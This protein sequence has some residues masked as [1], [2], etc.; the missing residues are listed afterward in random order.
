MLPDARRI[1]EAVALL[2]AGELVAFPT[3]TV[4][5]LGAD[6]QN[7]FAV[8]RIFAV[9]GRPASHPLIVHFSNFAAARAWAAEVPPTAERLA[10]AF[11]PGPLTLVLPKAA[12][13]PAAVTG[14]QDSVALRAPAHPVARALLAAFGRGIAAPSANRYGRISPTRAADVREELG[15]RI[16][17]VLDG[18]DCE[19]GLESTIVACLG[20]RV[21]LLRPGSISRSQ[22]E[23]VVGRVADPDAAAPRAPG[24]DRSHY[25]PGTPL[26]LVDGGSLARAVDTALA[27]GERVAVLA[28]TAGFVESDRVTWHRMPEAPAAYGRALYA[29]L[30]ALDA[31]GADCILAE[32][33]PPGEAWAAVADRLAR[34]SMPGAGE[35]GLSGP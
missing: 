9:K 15:D 23:D 30:R 33:V 19:V 18:G 25:A 14:A 31:A 22:L 4:Y 7:A 34:A 35:D 12:A 26:A 21:T 11:W 24:R 17:L 8:A 1:E 5:G 3:E 13:V 20:G 29:A 6:A 27:R 32:T 28:R 2:N 16:A 10:E